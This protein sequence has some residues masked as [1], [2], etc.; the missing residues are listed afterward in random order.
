VSPGYFET[1]GLPIV[2]GRAFLPSDRE[3]AEPV[4]IVSQEFA[5]TNWPNQEPI[6]KRVRSANGDTFFE[7]VGVAADLTN[8]SSEFILGFPVVYVPSSQGRFLLTPRVSG[9]WNGARISQT[10]QASEMQFLVRTSA[11]PAN[12]KVALRQV[13]HAA[14][15]SVWVNIQTIEER[16]EP[17]IGPQ[18]TIALC[19]TGFGALALVMACAGIYAILAYAVSQRT[20]EIGIRM[21][22]G[23]HRRE[24]LSMVMRRTLILIA[25]GIGLG[26]AGAFTLSRILSA[27][28]GGP[29]GLDARTSISVA[30]LLGAASLLASYLPSRKALRVDPVQALRCE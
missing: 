28:L 14:A 1:L 19:V 11:D 29:R 23:A 18:K 26:L 15:P 24:I 21:A 13:V 27:T 2:R 12:V 30:M 20:R 16:L 4:A 8:P 25:W 7:V 10:Y 17:F 22:L 6:G 3:G 5:R 9:V